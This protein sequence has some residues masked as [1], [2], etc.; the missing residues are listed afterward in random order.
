M[1]KL[2][3]TRRLALGVLMSGVHGTNVS[4]WLREAL[5][6]GLG[7]VCLFAEN[8]PDLATARR[9]TD[10]LRAENPSVVV[11]SDEE[12]GDVTRL[13]AVTGS[14]LPGNE[15][16]GV[17]D[18]EAITRS[19]A[20]ELGR[21]MSLAGIDLDLA[22]A[23][24]VAS[25]PLNPVIG[26]R[27]FGA[28]PE[29]VGRHGQ[30]FID[31]LRDVGVASCGKH[32]PGHG[33]TRTDSHV[34][35]PILS[36]KID[37]LDERDLKPF[38]MCR[39]DAIMTA[40]VVAPELGP[41]PASLSTWASLKVRES[42]FLGPILTDA[43]GMG[44]LSERM[45]L[46][47]AC[48]EA[49]EAGADLLCLD[50]PQ[51]RDPQA[52]LEEAVEALSTA[53]DAGRLDA[54]LLR[55]A[56][57]RAKSLSRSTSFPAFDEAAA[58]RTTANLDTLGLLVAHGALNVWG[59]VTVC[60][61]PLFLDL[62]HR[63]NHAAGSISPAFRQKVQSFWPHA[64]IE[65]T[66]DPEKVRKL[67]DATSGPVVALAKEFLGNSAATATLGAAMEAGERLIIVWAGM[68]S[69]RPKWGRMICCHGTGRPNAEVTCEALAGVRP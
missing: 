31:G 30:A 48:V 65:S 21:L 10:G 60:S 38:R 20:R 56:A 45:G 58:V 69:A 51:N 61:T 16:L 17:L 24:D 12:G 2:A 34:A 55:N 18:D 13:Q 47:E 36:A 28:D 15:A 26:V 66:P 43:L 53:L 63:A 29:L 4:G 62:R 11:A 44:A 37:T 57:A 59:N 52:A 23:L 19:C 8:T 40:H 54:P 7:S 9:L 5:H 49:L 41:A 22:P 33:D 6:D 64:R 67:I 32:Y 35:L 42:G 68:E 25:E 46:G 27:S 50:A 3:E 39:S 14:S 1:N